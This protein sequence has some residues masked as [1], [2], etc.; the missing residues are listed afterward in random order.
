MSRGVRVL[1]PAK[2]NWTL[3]VLR[4]RPDG[5]HELRSVLQT[6]DLCDVVTLTD[7][8]GITIDVGGP[9]GETL[10]DA[11]AERNLAYRA[12]LALRERVGGRRGARIVLEKH[13][14][15][16]AGLGGGSS[17]AAAVL[18]G[19]DLLWEL[20][21]PQINLIEI[22]GEVGSDPPFFVAGGT[23]AVRARG[24]VVEPLPDAVAPEILLATPPPGDRGDKTA[25]MFDAL[26]P[27]DFSEGD[28]T[29]GLREAVEAG[30]ALS[31]GELMNVFERVLTKQQ[32][33]TALALDALA[34]QG[35][36]AHLAG[37]GPSFFLLLDRR[38]DAAALSARVRDLGFEPRRVRALGR[39]A[40]LRT[41]DV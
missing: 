1:A 23:A 37:A 24:D 35:Q 41:E 33:D 4:I 12:A 7:A 32:P 11:P 5:Y 19:L 3:E 14:P 2:L 9:L 38:A 20:Q 27:D 34:A 18:R 28:A 22:A 13:I 15:V 21:Q 31:D 17:D 16:A 10:A 39:A 25:R 40:A 36:A 26:S 8:P 29:F 6:L 30:R